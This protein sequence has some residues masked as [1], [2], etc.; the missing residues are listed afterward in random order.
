MLRCGGTARVASSPVLSRPILPSLG[1]PEQPPCPGTRTAGG[2]QVSTGTEAACPAPNL[3][4]APP[5][6]GYLGLSTLALSGS[7][8]HCFS[9][10]LLYGKESWQHSHALTAS[11]ALVSSCWRV[12]IL[13]AVVLIRRKKA[14]LCFL[15]CLAPYKG[16]FLSVLILLPSVG[17][18]FQAGGRELDCIETE[19]LVYAGKLVWPLLSGGSKRKLGA[20]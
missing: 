8:A 2:Y 15:P 7:R 1:C 11:K 14:C 17:C 18:G 9:W 3:P 13:A 6:R 16:S 10:W 20:G 12:T 19:T 4:F 5:P